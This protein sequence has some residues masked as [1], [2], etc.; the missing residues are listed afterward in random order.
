[1]PDEKLVSLPKFGRAAQ[2]RA[3]SY[4]ETDNSVE[5]IWTTGATVPRRNW[6]TGKRYNETLELRQGAVRLDRLNA[7]A[8]F[9]DTHDDWSLRSVIGNVVPGSAK[10]EGGKGIARIRLS[11]APGDVDTVTK[12]RDGNIANI[13]VGYIIHKVEKT[14]NGDGEPEDWRVVDWE[15]ME[16]SAVPVPADAG[17]QVRSSPAE[18]PCEFVSTRATRSA[19]AASLARMRMR[20]AASRF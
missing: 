8:A 5:V 2:V 9:L 16:I 15:P 6:M 1:M 18:Y 14:E 4:D 10:I 20:R 7:G 13:S 17:A 11:N 12:I 3:A 19:T